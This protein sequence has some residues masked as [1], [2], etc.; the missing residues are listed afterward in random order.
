[1]GVQKVT[2]T[3]TVVPR[4]DKKELDKKKARGRG[5]GGETNR[6]WREK[7]SGDLIDDGKRYRAILHNNMRAQSQTC[8]SERCTTSCEAG[9][10]MA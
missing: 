8:K 9:T 7:G 1:M 6:V 4:R 5:E 3:G 2:Y 10:T